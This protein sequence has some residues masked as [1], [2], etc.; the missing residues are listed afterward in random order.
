MKIR[1]TR[2][3]LRSCNS[4]ILINTVKLFKLTD[5]LNIIEI[6]KK[7]IILTIKIGSQAIQEIHMY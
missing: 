3:K 5:I 4:Y 2:D 7:F 6:F 1:V